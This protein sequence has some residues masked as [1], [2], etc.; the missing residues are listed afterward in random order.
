M[1][2][3]FNKQSRIELAVLLHAKKNQTECAKIL[4]MSRPYRMFQSWSDIWL[5]KVS[6]PARKS[7]KLKLSTSDSLH[8]PFLTQESQYLCRWKW[9]NSGMPTF[10]LLRTIATWV[11]Q[12]WVN[13]F[14][15]VHG[16]LMKPVI[17]KLTLKQK[18]FISI[19]SIS[20]SLIKHSGQMLVAKDA[21]ALADSTYLLT[22]SFI[23]RCHF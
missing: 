17:W 10:S 12:S 11:K 21:H 19:E 7:T 1:Y 14:T 20:V 18:P 4:G 5:I 16:S 2:I 22:S 8:S 15:I 9:I 6:L 23:R 3:Q 13:I